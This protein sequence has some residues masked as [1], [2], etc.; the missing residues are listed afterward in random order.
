MQ[1]AAAKKQRQ[2]FCCHVTANTFSTR[3]PSGRNVKKGPEPSRPRR[4]S[5][6]GCQQTCRGKEGR[7]QPGAVGAENRSSKERQAAHQKESASLSA[8]CCATRNCSTCASR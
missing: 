2:A 5:D 1:N 7:Q 8:C 6:H 3:A 4:S